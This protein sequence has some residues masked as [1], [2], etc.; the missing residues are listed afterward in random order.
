LNW[1]GGITRLT[2][3]GFGHPAIPL[4]YLH[5]LGKH[6]QHRCHE[7]GGTHYLMN[8]EA[9]MPDSMYLGVET[10]PI[11]DH[12]NDSIKGIHTLPAA[13]THAGPRLP[14]KKPHASG[15]NPWTC[16][17][18]SIILT[19]IQG[20]GSRIRHMPPAMMGQDKAGQ[21]IYPPYPRSLGKS[22]GEASLAASTTTKTQKGSKA[23]PARKWLTEPSRVP[24][25]SS[26]RSLQNRPEHHR[27]LQQTIL[28]LDPL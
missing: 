16:T 10:R 17:K 2:Q 13:R 22:R 14:G 23:G 20:Q 3:E 26:S 27:S 8:N 19:S 6:D 11:I 28:Y 12:Y 18:A 24:S 15:K 1:V 7:I 4:R 9:S 21:G 25:T 5:S